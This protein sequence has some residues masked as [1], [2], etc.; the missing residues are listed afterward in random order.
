MDVAAVSPSP[1]DTR[2]AAS[3]APPL[4]P[5]VEAA[6]WLGARVPRPRRERLAGIHNPWGLAAGLVDSWAFLELC[7]HPALVDRVEAR[8]GPDIVLWE[9]ELV[10]DASGPD[11]SEMQGW[12]VEPGA[13]A[14]VAVDLE[15]ARIVLL[16]TATDRPAGGFLGP[17]QR[18]G[19]PVLLIH[20]FSAA[21]R[22]VR[23]PDHP[24]NRLGALRLPLINYALRPLWLVRG[25][26]LA[27]NDFVTGFS[28]VV[29][30]W[31]AA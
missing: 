1:P 3:A 13:C 16:E 11:C 5:V 18:C 20:Y 12:P 29:P 4:G 9:S 28:P 8:I 21:A 6:R 31:A 10:L 25:E 26:D 23:D 2:P 22:F 15:F 7:Q 19:R 27:G 30:Y 24:A 17:P 14:S